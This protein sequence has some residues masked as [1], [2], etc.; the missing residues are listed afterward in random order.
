MRFNLLLS[1]AGL[2][3]EDVSIIL[4]STNLHPFR[5][6]LPQMVADR[7]DLFDAYQSVHSESAAA[8]L[9]NRPLVASFV[10]L[11]HRRMVFAGLWRIVQIRD[12]PTHQIY[13]DPRYAEL[14]QNYGASDT[15]PARNISA[16]ELQSFF[17]LEA[18]EELS[19]LRGR[20]LIAS[21]RGRSY[22]RIATNLDADV[23]ALSE[24]S[25]LVS[26]VPDWRDFVVTGRQVRALP[27]SWAAR[28]AE[29]RGIYLIVDESDGARYVG[30]AYG[31]TNLL[32]R[33][34]AHVARNHG[35]TVELQHRD[36][37]RFR[38]SILERV[39]PDMTAEEVTAIESGWKLRI[40]SI[41]FGLNRN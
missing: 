1:D 3:V 15:A 41:A 39:G 16:R 24:D 5:E 19:S 32:G 30:A 37:S 21:P 36:P 17:Q 7:P 8:V 34:Q 4:H 18:M 10:P 20:L 28:L 13:S 38:F 35:I 33:W 14:E 26:S 11:Q 12:L 23:L 6:M 40:H 31:A 2:R 9:R 29:W 22:A 25:L 27:V